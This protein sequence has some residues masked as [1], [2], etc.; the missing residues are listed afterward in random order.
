MIINSPKT[1]RTGLTLTTPQTGAAD[2]QTTTYYEVISKIPPDLARFIKMTW[3]VCYQET[4][5]E[6]TAVLIFP[7]WWGQ[8][9]ILCENVAGDCSTKAALGIYARR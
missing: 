1:I 8:Y 7:E 4:F 5:V 9:V 2:I 6:F 3:N